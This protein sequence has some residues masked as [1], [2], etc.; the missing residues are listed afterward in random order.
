MAKKVLV[1]G[2]GG[3][4]GGF[5]VQ[6][7][8]RR[9]YEVW[10]AV[11][12]TT[13]REYLADGRIRFVVLDFNNPE[14]FNTTIRQEIDAHGPWDW[15]VH[16]LGATKC[17]NYDDFTR[18]NY[19]CLRLLVDTLRAYGGVTDGFVMM[20]SMSVLGVGDEKGYT[21]FSSDTIPMANTRYGLSKLRSETYLQTLPDFPW[22]VMRPTGVY[23]PRERDY[24]LMIKSI[25]SGFD[26][27][28]GYRRQLLTFIYVKDLAAAIFD[29]L[30]S[31]V[32]RKAY[33]LS[34]GRTYTQTEFR[35]IVKHILSKRFVVP[36]KAPLWMVRVVCAVAERWYAVR[37]K[38]STL[39]SDKYKIL[40]QRN[41]ACDIS[42][43]RR[44]FRFSPRYDLYDG[45]KEAIDWYKA[46]GWL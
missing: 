11:R 18:V 24:Y 16:N 13:S 39:N 2:A 37:G 5:I 12:A 23:G 17:V 15:V 38:A 22:L 42:A 29:A 44:D 45:L 19:G 40:R 31:G 10:A 3:F 4:I 1:T 28:V 20:S 14:A 26:F 43:A 35:S 46:E 33:L 21:P 8:L 7:A 36:V 9:G 27:S 25:A 32:R 30:A 6:E 41:W 34:D